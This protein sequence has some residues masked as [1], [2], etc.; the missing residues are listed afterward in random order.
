MQI[1]IIY[2]LKKGMVLDLTLR[3]RIIIEAAQGNKAGCDDGSSSDDKS[4]H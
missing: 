1:P 2:V 4:G 3:N